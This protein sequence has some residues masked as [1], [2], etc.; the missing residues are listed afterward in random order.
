M[1]VV[2]VPPGVGHAPERLVRR[3]LD[4]HPPEVVHAVV[5]D[6]PVPALNPDQETD[7]PARERVRDDVSGGPVRM[8]LPR[9][10]DGTRRSREKLRQSPSSRTS[11]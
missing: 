1:F 8:V 2:E 5:G 9:S 3:R 6:L 7:L 11:Q 4:A 10:S